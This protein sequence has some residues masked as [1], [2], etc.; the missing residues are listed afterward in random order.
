MVPVRKSSGYGLLVRKIMRGGDC[1][2]FD[3]DHWD[4]E[5]KAWRQTTPA[6]FEGTNENL[7]EDWHEGI[8]DE[9]QEIDGDIEA[10]I[11]A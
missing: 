8:E 6:A 2:T 10:E 3:Y 5:H 11:Y 1:Y 4:E 9:E 7:H